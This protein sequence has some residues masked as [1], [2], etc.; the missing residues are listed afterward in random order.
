MPKVE[1]NFW[2]KTNFVFKIR[3][4]RVQK[5]VFGKDLTLCG[6]F[7]LSRTC[8]RALY[9]QLMLLGSVTEALKRINISLS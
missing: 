1:L 9:G 5:G 2:T 8:T 7:G 3:P 4:K 6:M